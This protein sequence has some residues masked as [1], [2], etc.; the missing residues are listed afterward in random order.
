MDDFGTP[1]PNLRLHQF[2]QD[3]TKCESPSYSSFQSVSDGLKA[4]PEDVESTLSFVF[5]SLS[6]SAKEWRQ[7][8]NSLA[9]SFTLLKSSNP[10]ILQLLKQKSE[11]FKQLMEFFFVENR[12]D[13]GGVVRDKARMIFFLLNSPGML[14]SERPSPVKNKNSPWHV[15]EPYQRQGV[16]GQKPAVVF[17]NKEEPKKVNMFQGITVKSPGV[18]GNSASKKV[19]E[20][21]LLGDFET[22]NEFNNKARKP[23]LGFDLLSLSEEP[24]KMTSGPVKSDW[25]DIPIVQTP[26]KKVAEPVRCDIKVNIGDA[27]PNL[28]YLKGTGTGI[29]PTQPPPPAPPQ[30]DLESKLLSFDDLEIT[31]SNQK[32][33]P[34]RSYY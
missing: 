28:N 15:E 31:P 24:V 18:I 8:N 1:T 9:L 22:A 19:V 21:D 26:E 4:H 11:L 2:L 7:I 25:M 12:V 23:D 6:S 14:E 34:Q 10:Q 16:P 13:K 17:C 3:I 5:S 29:K 30:K 27:G 20:Q 33:K 32:P